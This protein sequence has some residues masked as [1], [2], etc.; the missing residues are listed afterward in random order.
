MLIKAEQEETVNF[1]KHE[2]TTEP[3]S[4]F[5]NGKMRKANEA[6]L[7][8]RILQFNMTINQTGILN[9]HISITWTIFTICYIKI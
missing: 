5:K 3:A 9:V 1:F 7:W 6:G 2:L 8:N 4:L